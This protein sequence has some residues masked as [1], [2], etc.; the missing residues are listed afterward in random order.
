VAGHGFKT[1]TMDYNFLANLNGGQTEAEP[2]KCADIEATVYQSYMNAATALYNGNRA[3]L[4]IG[5]HFNEWACGAFTTSLTRF[6]EDFKR[7]H[8]D[9]QFISNADLEKWLEAQDP[10]VLARLQAQPEPVY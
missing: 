2:A 1:L 4:F 10:L 7:A 8:P 9:V 5:N 3:P 6:I